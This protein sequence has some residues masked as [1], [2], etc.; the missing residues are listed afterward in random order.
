MFTKTF[1]LYPFSKRNIAIISN[2][3]DKLI[4]LAEIAEANGDYEKYEELMNKSAHIGA[5]A[6]GGL[7]GFVDTNCVWMTGK[8][9]AEAKKIVA[10]A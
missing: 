3:A 4:D 6:I 5:L 10:M 9:I 8:D 2:Y 1:K 7:H